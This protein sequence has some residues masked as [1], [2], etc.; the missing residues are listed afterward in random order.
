[1][2]MHRTFLMV[3]LLVGW[4]AATQAQEEA[5]SPIHPQTFKLNPADGCYRYS[6]DAVE[7]VGRFKAG[8]YLGITMNTLDA[9]G[10]PSPPDKEERVPAMDAPECRTEA[11]GFWFGPLPQSKDYLITF[12]PR[13]AFGSSAVVTLCGRTTPPRCSERQYSSARITVRTLQVTAGSAGSGEPYFL[14]RS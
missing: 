1:M 5:P 14:S 6:G 4:P 7:F 2:N 9:N 3:G 11:S 13:A 10:L 8:S 12:I